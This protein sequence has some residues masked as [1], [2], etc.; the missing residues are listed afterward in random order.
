MRKTSIA[1]P[2]PK[3]RQYSTIYLFEICRNDSSAAKIVSDITIYLQVNNLLNPVNMHCRNGLESKISSRVRVSRLEEAL[4]CRENQSEDN[5]SISLARF[6]TPYQYRLIFIDDQSLNIINYFRRYNF[7][8][9]N[10]NRTK[11]IRSG[12]RCDGI[13]LTMTD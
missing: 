9:V 6:A 5:P 8:D 4:L 7:L 11:I 2:D 3:Q 10:A 13:P 1:S 12:R